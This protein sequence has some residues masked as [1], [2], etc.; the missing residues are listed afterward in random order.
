MG[1]SIPNLGRASDIINNGLGF[2]QCG[3]PINCAN[4][5][6]GGGDVQI[7]EL[8]PQMN[9]DFTN[10]K[11]V[12]EVPINRS[13]TFAVNGLENMRADGGVKK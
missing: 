13:I 3:S 11:S 8:R 2:I 9:Q 10:I 12:S 7:E 6:I 4:V 5:R 1:Y